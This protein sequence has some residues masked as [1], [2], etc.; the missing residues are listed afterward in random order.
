MNKR[1][2]CVW[3]RNYTSRED[4]EPIKVRASS[5]EEAHKIAAEYQPHRFGIRNVYTLG[6]FRKATGWPHTWAT[7]FRC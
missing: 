6:E 3:M 1:F 7:K 2:Y 5:K 4:D